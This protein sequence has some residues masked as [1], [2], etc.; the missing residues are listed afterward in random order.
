MTLPRPVAAVCAALCACA[1]LLAPGA[2]RAQSLTLRP[3]VVPLEGSFGQSLTQ[4]LTLSNDSDLQM[5]FALEARDVVVRNGKRTFV[6]AGQLDDSAAASALM[7][8]RSV[9]IEPHRS[10]SVDVT[11]TLPP[12]MRHRAVVVL[13]RGATPVA[14]GKQQALLSL[15]ALFTFTLSTR[16]SLS[17]GA[18]QA[19]PPSA[20]TSAT[21]R[22][23]LHNDGDEPLVP[24]GMAVILDAAGRLIGKAPFPSRRLL[25]G[26]SA[27]MVAEY[28][29]ELA[30]GR[31]RAVATF[32]A[33]GRTATQSTSFDV[34]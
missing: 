24:S 6:E 26:E 4:R 2:A 25:P 21:L 5:S 23:T 17:A 34:P 30:P 18:L 1:V 22:S 33:A 9:H 7:T 28:A 15:G 14:A 20:S 27:D 31:Y 29:G 3:A 8:Q 10:A 11:L 32:D 19:E 12:A 13:F 16:L